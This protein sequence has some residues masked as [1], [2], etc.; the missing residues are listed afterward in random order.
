[1]PRAAASNRRPLLAKL[2]MLAKQ[3]GL[4]DDAYRD[5]LERE[6]GKRS[7][8]DLTDGELAKVCDQLGRPSSVT[9]AGRP[10]AASPAVA[11]PYA[12]K[13]RALWIAAWHLGV[14]RNNSDA[15]MLAFVKRQTGIE[16]TRFL[17][18][19]RAANRAIE[20]LKGWIAREAGVEWGEPGTDPRRAVVEAQ[21]RRLE[22]LGNI[23]A[24]AFGTSQFLEDYVCRVSGANRGLQYV[25][26][27]GWDKAI[28]ALGARLRRALA[29]DAAR[30][31]EEALAAK[32]EPV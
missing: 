19:P 3:R 17:I 25:D 13:L 10:A 32:V 5:F 11:G 20:G 30:R 31:S 9:G 14:T 23:K 16:H 12:G 7:A 26:A 2:H 15:A 28:A 22:G 6:T 21:V 27:A 1:M 29:A 18:E 8:R 24:G 4:D